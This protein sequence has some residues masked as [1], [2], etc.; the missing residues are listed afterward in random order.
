MGQSPSDDESSSF[1]EEI[2]HHLGNAMN[3]YIFYFINY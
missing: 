1:G 3:H 2:I